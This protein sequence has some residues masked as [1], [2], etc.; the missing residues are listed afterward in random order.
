M[1]SRKPSSSP[2]SVIS[3]EGWAW[4]KKRRQKS[5]ERLRWSQCPHCAKTP[6][7]AARGGSAQG[8]DYSFWVLPPMP[9]CALWRPWP[10]L[11]LS[12]ALDETRLEQLT[13]GSD[14]TPPTCSNSSSCL[15]V[16][17]SASAR[18][19]LG[20]A[21]DPRAVTSPWQSPCVLRTCPG[22]GVRGLVGQSRAPGN[23]S[24]G[25]PR[26]NLQGAGSGNQDP[27]SFS[28]FSQR[29]ITR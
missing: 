24:S 25:C 8:T 22:R 16:L 4:V 9:H 18:A 28:P 23:T 6:G 13:E 20:P 27:L 17:S 12:G 10:P 7:G 21:E 2:C 3:Q 1:S 14:L 5:R 15:P 11:T 19:L 26:R 29:P